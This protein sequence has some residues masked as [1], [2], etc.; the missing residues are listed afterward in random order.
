M[1]GRE[2]TVIFW[3]FVMSMLGVIDLVP[4]IMFIIENNWNTHVIWLPLDLTKIRRIVDW[5]SRSLI[6]YWMSP[7][8]NVG[9]QGPALMVSLD[10]SLSLLRLA[11]FTPFL[12]N[13]CAKDETLSCKP[14]FHVHPSQS[15]HN[16]RRRPSCPWVPWYVNAR[17]KCCVEINPGYLLYVNL[18]Y[19][20][21][22]PSCI[23]RPP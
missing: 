19:I 13:K 5:H 15:L 3:C 17:S 12:R 22:Q 4:D 10:Y 8:R 6:I 9:Y 20:S 23:Y 21:F 7:V 16:F 18:V 1:G 2:T 14:N 11:K